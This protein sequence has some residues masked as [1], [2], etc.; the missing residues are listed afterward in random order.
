MALQKINKAKPGEFL[1]RGRRTKN[2]VVI[3]V[4]AGEGI[5]P[6][7]EAWLKRHLDGQATTLLESHYKANGHVLGG[8]SDKGFNLLKCLE[9]HAMEL[10]TLRIS[11]FLKEF[12][13]PLPAILRNSQQVPGR[14]QGKWGRD[15]DGCK[16]FMSTWAHPC[17]SR[18]SNTL[19][20]WLLSYYIDT[21]ASASNPPKLYTLMEELSR[22][23][24]SVPSLKFE[25]YHKD[26]PR[27]TKRGIAAAPETFST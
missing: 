3:D 24:F 20:S 14:L 17:T 19:M 15:Y 11:I 25:V 22:Q 9:A 27:L 10:K 8:D 13:P 23:G 6:E 16:D 4:F 12:A 7:K 26:S 5:T 2:K 21:S 18:C 1:V